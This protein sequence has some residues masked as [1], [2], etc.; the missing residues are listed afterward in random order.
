[1]SADRRSP[2][3]GSITRSYYR[4]LP[5]KKR[6][7]IN[8]TGTGNTFNVSHPRVIQLVTDS[9]RYWVRTDEH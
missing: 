4:L 5:D 7:Y 6:Y 9:L 2:L 8:D 1:M 3:K